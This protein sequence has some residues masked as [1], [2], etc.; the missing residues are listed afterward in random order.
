MLNVLQITEKDGDIKIFERGWLDFGVGRHGSVAPAG[1]GILFWRC[2]RDCVQ[3]VPHRTSSRAIFAASLRDSLA[4]LRLRD[5]RVLMQPAEDCRTVRSPLRGLGFYFGGVPGI[6]SG[7]FRIGLH[8]GLFS[9]R[10]SGT[11]AAL[12]FGTSKLVPLQNLA[13]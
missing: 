1:L 5:L 11:L 2:S 4:A 3:C 13:R 8:P 7:A 6:A 9:R 12:R 10:P